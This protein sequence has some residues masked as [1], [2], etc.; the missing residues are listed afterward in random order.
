MENPQL[1]LATVLLSHLAFMVV[2]LLGRRRPLRIADAVLAAF[3]SAYAFM[4]LIDVL[5]WLGALGRYDGLVWLYLPAQY[6]LAPLIYLYVGVLTGA[7]PSSWRRHLGWL[8]LGPLL[9]LAVGAVPFFLLLSE[10]QRA[11]VLT[12]GLSKLGRDQWLAQRCLF[13]VVACV[14]LYNGVYV[15]VSL[16]RLRR[17]LRTV[18]NFFSDIEDKQ[19]S[20]LRWMLLVLVAAAAA[21]V[22]ATVFKFGDMANVVIQACWIYALTF[23]AL[24][25][26]PIYADARDLEVAEEAAEAPPE[27]RKYARSALTEADLTRIAAKLAQ[28]MEHDRLHRD[29]GLTLRNLSERTGVAPAYLSQTLNVHLGRSFF[30]YVNG[31]RIEDACR[32]LSDPA[33]SIAAIGEEVGFRSRSTFYSAFRKVVGESVG[34]YR[35][36][37]LQPPSPV[38]AGAGPDA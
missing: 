11:L 5:K 35:R 22:I 38:V 4:V 2:W 16:R 1:I 28:A 30:D 9:A 12:E 20:W 13:G 21:D 3:L 25:Q 36:R 23:L 7:Q 24:G 33:R 8:A 10:E 15:W 32:Q 31:W 18:E 19:L 14:P 17:H 6:A 37:A 34:D 27:R 29:A 26:P